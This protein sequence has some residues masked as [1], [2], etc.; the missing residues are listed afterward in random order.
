MKE[1]TA[2]FK[3]LSKYYGPQNWWPGEGLE[4]AV[5]AVLT[6]QTSWT[7]VEKALS[8]IK[9]NNC[10]NLDCL[11]SLPLSKLEEFI[12]SSGYYKVKARRLKNLVKLLIENSV[13]NRTKLL[14]VNGIGNE[15]ADSILL[16]QFE[17][18]Y[19]VIDEYTFRILERIG[20]YSGRNYLELQRIF[21]ENIPSNIQIYK[22]YHALLVVHGKSCC[23]K[24]KP[25]CVNCPLQS[26]CKYYTMNNE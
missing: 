14:S 3:E 1:L 21:M 11:H 18:P 4:I 17:K 6:Q 15:T 10:M 26:R 16:Y 19:F 7:N 24:N 13:P 23:T 9:E 12:R 8:K 25:K 20:I 2:I 5:G 22:E